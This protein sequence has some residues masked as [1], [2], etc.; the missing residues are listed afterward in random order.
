MSVSR[1]TPSRRTF[2]QALGATGLAAV[3]VGG[4]TTAASRGG[5]KAKGSADDLKLQLGFL[6]NVQVGGFWLADD[7]GYYEKAGLQPKFL[8][9][10]PN[11]PAP[12]VALNAGKAV[13]ATEA[14]TVR[15][16]EYLAK[17]QDVVIIGLV[18]Q[19]SP[20]GL[21][22]LRRRPVRT[23]A[24][25]TG[26]RILAGSRNRPNIDA[27][28]TINEVDDYKFVP[29]GV[30]VGPLLEGQGDAL[31]AFATNQPIALRQQEDMESDKDF[32]FA[33]FSDLDY[34]LLSEMILV[35]RR[36]LDENRETVVKFMRA[37][38]RGFQDFL[39]HPDEAA[40]LATNKY[41]KSLGLDLEQQ[42][43]AARAEVPFMRSDRTAKKGLLTIDLDYVSDKVYP[44]LEA[45]GVKGLPDLTKVVD[46]SVLDDVY[47]DGPRV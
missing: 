10:G 4:C 22:S 37:T 3:T 33:Y 44:S 27:L 45:S 21:V 25:L 40:E 32:Y 19:K 14:N 39:E 18:Y 28:M 29:A 17:R 46:T 2:L 9:G 38:A 11:S 1:I 42:K 24:E 5:G 31:L 43:A 34:H 12:E 35:D 47:R 41:G 36:F 7:N 16:F 23:R 30:D 26:A 8:P 20:N 13:L 15:L 6:P